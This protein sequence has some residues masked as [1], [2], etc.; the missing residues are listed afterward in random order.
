[1]L[2]NLELLVDKF[3]SSHASILCAFVESLYQLAESADSARP[4]AEGPLRPALSRRQRD[5]VCMLQ[6]AALRVVKL[7][8]TFIA[9]PEDQRLVLDLLD[10][11]AEANSNVRP[12]K[13]AQLLRTLYECE[14]LDRHA[15]VHWHLQQ[16]VLRTTRGELLRETAAPL[17]AELVREDEDRAA[18]SAEALDDAQRLLLA[19]SGA[20]SHCSSVGSLTPC[21]PT[22]TAAAAGA[23]TPLLE[24]TATKPGAAGFG[25]GIVG[26]AVGGRGAVTT[27]TSY[28]S[29]MCRS[30]HAAAPGADRRDLARKASSESMASV[31]LAAVAIP[32]GRRTQ[33]ASPTSYGMRPAKQVSFAVA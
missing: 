25:Q 9:E 13:H 4:G 14:V 10:G 6:Q 28:V 8:H 11:L 31:T 26:K 33:H 24:E 19:A 16:P 29:V 15:L 1:M 23:L 20:T 5:E 27:S 18:E 12:Q 3:A 32:N 30:G 22:P 17:I 7:L 2:H 21:P